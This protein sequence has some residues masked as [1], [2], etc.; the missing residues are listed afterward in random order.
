MK[1]SD[2]CTYTV[3]II[4]LIAVLLLASC[5]SDRKPDSPVEEDPENT[6]EAKALSDLDP[7]LDMDE[8]VRRQLYEWNAFWDLETEMKNFGDKETGELSYTT[9][10][11]IRLEKELFHDS[12][13]EQLNSS[14]LKSRALVIRTFAMKLK[15]QIDHGVG[16]SDVDSTRIKLMEAYNAFRFQVA[17]A[18]RNKIYDEFLQQSDSILDS[19]PEIN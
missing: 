15:D 3:S 1:R 10:E 8:E 2:S 13:P 17:D 9:E 12:L 11:L 5:R 7:M 14:A 18:L 6:E 16:Q 4:T 19:L